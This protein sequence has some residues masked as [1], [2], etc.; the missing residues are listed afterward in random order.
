[1][2]CEPFLG[3]VCVVVVVVFP[4]WTWL[5]FD[6]M[7]LCRIDGN[8]VM[9]FSLFVNYKASYILRKYVR[10]LFTYRPRS[11]A[12]SLP[13]MSVN[14][15]YMTFSSEKHRSLLT[16][17]SVSAECVVPTLCQSCYCLWV[18]DILPCKVEQHNLSCHL[19]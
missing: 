18:L 4:R 16:D 12:F 15:C 14:I 19:V 13:V 17:P 9:I 6:C 2:K 5:W 10:L 1:M 8:M 11:I 7:Q 3:S